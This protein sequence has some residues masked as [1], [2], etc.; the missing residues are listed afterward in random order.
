MV[1]KVKKSVKKVKKKALGRG[2]GA[3]LPKKSLKTTDVSRETSHV[4]NKII[5]LDIKS[6]KADDMQPR[7]IFDKDKLEE[8]SVSIKNNGIIQPILVRPDGDQYKII[9]GERRFRACKLLNLKTIPAMVETVKD[10]KAHVIALIENIQREGL[11]AIEEGEAYKKLIDEGH[12][13]QEALAKKIGKSRS[14]IAN[15]MRLLKLPQQV[16]QLLIEKKL[17]MG[18]LRCLLSLD[19]QD[20]QIAFANK[21]VN[22]S[23][24]VR[25]LEDIIYNIGKEVAEKKPKVRLKK[26]KDD[27][28]I[29]TDPEIRRFVEKI[30]S[31]FYCKV[32][33]TGS[34]AKGVLRFDYSSKDDLHRILELLDVTEY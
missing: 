9:F 24:S 4:V 15:L 31:K 8:L 23:L 12:L 14:S 26:I 29:S 1:K 3:L 10:E 13:T 19:I 22:E 5:E 25:E 18:H 2:L 16:Q 27:T 20:K 21:A 17:S 30:Q 11:N 6:I 32:M 28:C 33:L 34:E 7:V